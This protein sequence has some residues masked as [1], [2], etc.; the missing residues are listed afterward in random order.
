MSKF[1]HC[2][3]SILY[4][5]LPFLKQ[6]MPFL[7]ENF[8]QLIFFDLNVGTH[9]PHFSTD[10]SHE[11][12][13]EY[14]DPEDKITLIEK[15]NLEGIEHW[16]GAGSVE[17]QKMFALGSQYV[18]D[19]IDVFWCTDLDEFFHKSF[20][21]KV[22]TIFSEFPEINSIDMR[23][24]VFWKNMNL[25][26]ANDNDDGFDMF[27]RVCRHKKGNLYGHCSI[28]HQ[29]PR[30]HVIADDRYY[31]FAWLGDNRVE[32]KLKHYSTPPTG[33]PRNK[34]I[35][36]DYLKEVWY[37]FSSDY[38]LDSEEVFGAPRMHPN[39]AMQKG[40][41]KFVGE[42]PSYINIQQLMRELYK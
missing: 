28:H 26:L 17:K 13:A 42:L 38:N 32:S 7:Y 39:Q 24:Y 29:F 19:E 22:E 6:K 3:F 41:K 31:H 21:K 9:N 4:N 16:T 18:N 25:I 14:P 27:S 36:D 5:E 20:I 8:N 35:Y 37:N 30:N 23:H 15:D 2:H 33:S 12:I 11:F 34:Q 1:K 10:G 40:I